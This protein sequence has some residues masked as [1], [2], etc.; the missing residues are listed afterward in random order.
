MGVPLPVTP[1]ALFVRPYICRSAFK[2]LHDLFILTGM[3]FI[4]GSFAEWMGVLD[5]R[6]GS[7]HCSLSPPEWKLAL[8]G[9]DYDAPLLL[10]SSGSSVAHLA[11]ISQ[12]T[13]SLATEWSPSSVP[14]PASSSSS[15][16]QSSIAES[17][18]SPNTNI[19]LDTL[20]HKTVAEDIL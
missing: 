1:L 7:T 20:A 2:I 12:N 10:P 11:F 9:V 4:F 16:L 14:V 13:H 6:P 8:S 18:T 17:A 3:D 15:L 5:N 19:K